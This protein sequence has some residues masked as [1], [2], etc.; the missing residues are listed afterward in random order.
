M[1]RHPVLVL[2][3]GKIGRMVAHFL[4][5]CGD[6]EL[7]VGD[8]A[9]PAVAQMRQRLPDA[10]SRVVDF[11]SRDALRDAMRG[12]TAVLSCAPFHCN[13]LIAEVAREV[14][15][16]YLDLTEDVLVTERVTALATAAQT[17]FVP[18]CGLAP[19]FI[20][21]IANK[22]LGP[23]QDVTD[24]RLRVGALPRYPSNM[25]QYNLT[26]STEG[27]INEYCNL[28]DVLWNGELRQVQPLENLETL[29][30]DGAEYE[31]FNTSGGLGT[32]AATL[33]GRVQNVNYKS[34]RYPG[35]CRLI[36]FLLQ[37][38]RMRERPQMLAEIFDSSL[39][40]TFRD[41][42]VIFVSATGTYRGRLTENV[43]ARTIRHR[44]IDGENWS[45]IQI[46]TAAGICAV[47]DL[48]LDRR[49]PQ[50]GLV[51]QEDVSYDEFI[52]NRFGRHYAEET[53][54]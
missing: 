54:R 31:A 48:L 50:R 4:S 30:I 19:G 33:L 24:L 12:R 52:Q 45:A 39:P 46:T 2:G 17:A 20:T 47:L 37:D 22:L 18:Q 29:T 41:Q 7:R 51:R 14:G 13:P 53:G 3:A 44:E 10:D 32:L 34:I 36:K 11:R 9:E 5:R 6:Y 38:L 15:L 21:I 42:V 49:L 25:L 26:W 40:T 28:C 27:L 8:V 23:M 43:Y 16:H 35:H 1:T